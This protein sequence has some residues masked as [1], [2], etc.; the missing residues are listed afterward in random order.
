MNIAQIL[1]DI[2]NHGLER[3]FKRYYSSYHAYVHS[4]EDPQGYGRLQLIIP[5]ITGSQPLLKWA[6]QKGRYAGKNYGS[7]NI[8]EK[9]EMVFVEFERGNTS[10]PIWTYG[11]H[12]KGELEDEWK[13]PKDKWFKTPDGFWVRYKPEGPEFEVILPNGRKLVFTNNISLVTEGKI[14]LGKLEEAAEPAVLGNKAEDAL[15]EIKDA[16]GDIKT[17]LTQI[18]TTDATIASTLGLSYPT[19][20]STSFLPQFGVKL[21]SIEQKI[22]A[23]KSTK[24]HLD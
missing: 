2:V 3:V 15:N 7:W 21:Q 24:V 4:N 11:Y 18:A 1:E 10:Y 8:P 14:F 9:G 22:Q 20:I 5:T 19:Q 6:W 23:I 17:L 12:G 13:N 16:L